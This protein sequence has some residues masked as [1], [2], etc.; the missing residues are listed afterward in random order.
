[1]GLRHCPSCGGTK[2]AAWLEKRRAE[3]LPVPYFHVVF[4]LPHELSALALGNRK[5]LYGLLFD[6]A[7]QTLL[8]VATGPRH[9][10]A[11]LG[12]LAVLHTWGQQLEHH[13]HIHAVVPGG[14]L[15]A[16]GATWIAC[17]PN[18]L[19][20]VKVLG[21]VFRGKYLTGRRACS[22]ALAVRTGQRV[23]CRIPASR[24]VSSLRSVLCP[25]IAEPLS[26]ATTSSRLLPAPFLL[27]ALTPPRIQ[28]PK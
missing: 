6:A 5:T 19:A 1:M 17:R 9:L 26:L 12:A 22:V 13:P 15:S 8:Q 10:G 25:S 2:R 16:D 28:S 27:A 3:L 23:R 24:E 14:G 7:A 20:P 4:T 21:R 11:R 18:F